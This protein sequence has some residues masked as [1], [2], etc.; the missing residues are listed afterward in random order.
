[1]FFENQTKIKT[2]KPQEILGPK[3]WSLTQKATTW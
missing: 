1:M 2:L 3:C